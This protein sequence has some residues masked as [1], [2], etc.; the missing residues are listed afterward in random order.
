VLTLVPAGHWD[1]ASGSSIAAAEVTA[2]VALLLSQRPHLTAAEVFRVLTRT[3][4]TLTTR[5]TP[6]V[7]VN[8]CAALADVLKRVGCGADAD[9]AAATVNSAAARARAPKEVNIAN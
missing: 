8:A 7:S 6:L 9:P 5:A 4:Q 3:S 1:F 2:T